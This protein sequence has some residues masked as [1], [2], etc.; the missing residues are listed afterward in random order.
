M[1]QW[2]VRY[3]LIELPG[4]HAGHFA[5]LAPCPPKHLSTLTQFCVDPHGFDRDA[6]HKRFN[7]DVIAFFRK[8]LDR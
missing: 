1:R 6:F 5:F 2:T 4:N 7:A 8:H 3:R